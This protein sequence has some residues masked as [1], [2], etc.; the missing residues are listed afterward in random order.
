MT[1]SEQPH[2][3]AEP[4][5]SRPHMPGYGIVDATEGKGLL[6]WSWAVERLTQARTYWVGTTRPDGR[7]HLMPLWAVWLD[8]TLCFSTD[9]ESVKGRNLMANPHCTVAVQDG[10]EAV[11]VEGLCRSST[12]QSL[13]RRFSKIYS[14]KYSWDMEGFADP[15][16][17]LRPTTVFAF[18]AAPG[19]FTATATRW[20]FEV[21][22]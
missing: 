3:H 10:E 17:V 1:E 9:G 21:A 7:P 12:D 8:D 18:S 11:I 16:Y 13:R 2:S 5:A 4:R 20:T 14:D 15:V 19:E 6:P 22:E